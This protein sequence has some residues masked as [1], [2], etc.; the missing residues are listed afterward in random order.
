MNKTKQ[1][2]TMT[3]GQKAKTWPDKT[4]INVNLNHERW[5]KDSALTWGE[6]WRLNTVGRW[7]VMGCSCET[8]TGDLS[9][10][11]VTGEKTWQ[12]INLNV[13]SKCDMT[14]LI[15][16]N[17]CRNLPTATNTSLIFSWLMVLTHGSFSPLYNTQLW[18]LKQRLRKLE[19][20][21]LPVKSE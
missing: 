3:V 9:E 14:L 20:K 15:S 8:K 13:N 1:D 6:T 2:K 12:E 19:R 7:L 16:D 21:G 10:P 5:V 11:N 17:W 18:T 4:W